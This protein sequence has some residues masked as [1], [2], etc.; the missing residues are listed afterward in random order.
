[1][2]TADG[3][4]IPLRLAGPAGGPPVLLLSG[5]P[6]LRQLPARRPGHRPGPHHRGGPARRRSQRW[7]SPRPRARAGRP[8]GAPAR[9][10]GSGPG[11]WSATRPEPTWRWPTR[12]STRRRCARWS[13]RAAPACRTTGTGPPTT[14][15]RPTPSPTSASPTPRTCTPR[16][17][18]A[19]GSGSRSPTCSTGWPTSPC[20]S[21]WWWPATT[22]ARRGRCGRSPRW[23]PAPA[24]PSSPGSRTTCGTRTRTCG[25]QLVASAAT[26]D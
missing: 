19:G 7:R 26:R 10:C 21:R 13:Q 2:R 16:C 25:R 6:G 14:T 18:P 1:M 12:S 3:V 22:S 24:S 23:C 17:W 5:G 11:R 9:T 4:E 15:R 20:R 8:G